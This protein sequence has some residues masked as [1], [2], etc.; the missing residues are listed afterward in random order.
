MATAADMKKAM[1]EMAKA[2]KVAEAA[3]A[4][5][6][7][8]AAAAADFENIRGEYMARCY[9]KAKGDADPKARK[10]EN[11][12]SEVVTPLLNELET[13][14]A[15]LSAL[16]ATATAA[17][18][19]KAGKKS[20][21][22]GAQYSFHPFSTDDADDLSAALCHIRRVKKDAS[23]KWHFSQCPKKATI[24]GGYCSG[25]HK[26]HETRAAKFA[27]AAGQM[28]ISVDGDIRI[29]GGTPEQVVGII[30][31]DPHIGFIQKGVC[32]SF[33]GGAVKHLKPIPQNIIEL[34]NLP[35]DGAV[36]GG[37]VA[38]AAGGE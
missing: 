14:R 2:L 18:K 11:I 8:D 23:G 29:V 22:S 10:A 38:V 30:T 5:A 33:G 35:A 20:K 32:D 27:D 21:T 1:A 15:E 31:G 17:P 34:Y 25:C 3:E 16:K 19:A 9:N 7:S 6:K 24:R 26:T 4:K 13:A 12:I 28:K 37:E 36:A